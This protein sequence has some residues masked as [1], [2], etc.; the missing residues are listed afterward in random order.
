MMRP[1]GVGTALSTL[2]GVSAPLCRVGAAAA[3][4]AF[5]SWMGVPTPRVW[6]ISASRR[7][8]AARAVRLLPARLR[9]AAALRFP[10]PPRATRAAALHRRAPRTRT[11]ARLAE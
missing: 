6:L 8:S 2:R 1:L 4:N 5:R 9:L 3:A 11:V 10:V 7:L